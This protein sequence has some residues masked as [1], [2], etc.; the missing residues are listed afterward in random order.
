MSYDLGILSIKNR[1]S[2]QE[3]SVLY[4]TLCNGD[5]SGVISNSSV[6]MF[7]DELTAKHPEI[8]NVPDEEIDNTD[9]C[10]WSVAF[11]RSDGH[12]IICSVWSKAEYVFELILNLAGKHGL[13]TYCPQ[14]KIIIYPDG[15]EGG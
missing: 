11:D 1:I 8:D 2:N 10:P 4:A 7:Y 14:S 12:I 9:L 5:Y 3:A 6:N 13:A 15:S